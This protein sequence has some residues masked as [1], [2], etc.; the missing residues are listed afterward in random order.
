MFSKITC[1]SLNGL[2]GTPVEVETDCN[3]GFVSCDIVGLPDTAV[4][5]SRE[6]VRSAI[7]NSAYIFPAN[8]ITINLAPADLKKE[9]SLFDLAI[10]ISILKA[11]NQVVA[12]TDGIVFLGEL[13]LDGALRPVTGILPVL[14]SAK[15]A[16]Y[17]RFIIPQKNANEASYIEGTEV[18]ALSSLKQAVQFI[19]GQE[20]FTPV[21]HKSFKITQSTASYNYD[22]NLVKGQRTAKRAIEIA[23][24]GGH[25]VLLSGP[26][27]TGKTMLARCI[28]TIMPDMTFDE[29]LEVTKIH[30]VA[31]ELSEEGIVSLRPFRTPHHTATTV[32]L[33]GGGNSKI[34]PGEISK[35]HNGVL[36]LDELPEYSR[37]TLE[38][39]RQPL[40]DKII[41]VTRSGGAVTFPADFVLCASM[42]PCPCGNYGSIDKPCTCSP[43]QIRKYKS[44][45]SGPLL[46]RI[47][48]Q[49]EVDNVKYDDLISE[50]REESSAE[51]KAR[52][53]MARKIQ[54]VRF[55]DDG[56]TTNSNMGE[57]LLKKYCKLSAQCEEIIRQAFETL[58]LSVRARARIIKVARTIADLELCENISPKHILEATSYRSSFGAEN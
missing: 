52:V 12:S 16:G 9:G 18:Y 23:V 10:A 48:L 38:S 53:E 32:S 7:K 47:D 21:Q 51:I 27:G 13:A 39:L 19:T 36:F 29:A 55:A 46:D 5:E 2:A 25:N 31:G 8:K 15:A 34:H 35:A 6:R 14:I 26:P 57:R 17:T 33:C 3:K 43:M 28:P 54:R 24:A 11:S 20:E 22:M 50:D 42:N 49:V 41:T 4:K 44:K 58:N 37:S 40:E 1:F 56:I 45:I 30:S